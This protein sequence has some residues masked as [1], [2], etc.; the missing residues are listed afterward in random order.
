V[1]PERARRG[2]ARALPEPVARA[3]A[4]LATYGR[5]W[6]LC[7][8]YAV[9]AHLG[10]VTRDH[11]DVDV[12]VFHEDQRALFAH[13]RSHLPSARLVGHD[14][15]VADDSDETWDGRALS[16]PAHVHTRSEGGFEPEFHLN[17]REG[18]SWVLR[19]TPRI[20]RPTDSAI[21]A[22]PWRVPVVSA[23]VVL[24]YKAVPPMWRGA[25]PDPPR[26]HDHQDV[27]ALAPLLG[28]SQRAW[29]SQALATARPDHPWRDVLGS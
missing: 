7:G 26:P 6:A 22:S 14:D 29:L 5:P 12:A 8:G 25:P 24:Y 19:R 27:R 18:Q 10:R 1:T 4:L 11:H 23:E 13:L 15:A 20:A 2:A 17:D 9:D 3:A 21:V 28:A 16:F